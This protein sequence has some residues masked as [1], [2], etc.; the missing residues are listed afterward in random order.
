MLEALVSIPKPQ[1]KKKVKKKCSALSLSP[2]LLFS[3]A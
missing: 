2:H 1:E 3:T